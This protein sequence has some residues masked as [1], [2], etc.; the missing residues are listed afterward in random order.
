[1]YVAE[2]QVEVVLS[3]DEDEEDSTNRHYIQNNIQN[4]KLPIK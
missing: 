3:T 4:N 1:M 2:L